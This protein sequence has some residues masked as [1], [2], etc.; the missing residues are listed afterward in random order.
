MKKSSVDYSCNEIEDIQTAVLELMERIVSK[1]NERGLFYISRIEP[2]GSMVEK[3]ALCKTDYKIN[4]KGT[5]S[6][7]YS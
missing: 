3:A 6:E 4:A 1:I 7:K 5:I 2:C